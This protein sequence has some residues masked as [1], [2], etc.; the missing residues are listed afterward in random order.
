LSDK[1][2]TP[3]EASMISR[4]RHSDRPAIASNDNGRLSDTRLGARAASVIALAAVKGV[5]TL[6]YV[7]DGVMIISREIAA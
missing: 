7:A 2:V 4:H 5:V 6:S 1:E 3:Q